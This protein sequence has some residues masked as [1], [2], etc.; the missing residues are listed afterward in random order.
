MLE[1]CC[2][3]IVNVAFLIFYSLAIVR[4]MKNFVIKKSRK[5]WDSHFFL[6]QNASSYW[7]PLKIYLEAITGAALGLDDGALL[8]FD[9]I[10]EDWRRSWII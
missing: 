2:E 8:E 10:I 5:Q 9:I 1:K 6:T 3:N 7:P 4:T